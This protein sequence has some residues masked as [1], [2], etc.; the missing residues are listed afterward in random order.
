MLTTYSDDFEI[1]GL[2]NNNLRFVT[3]S[4]LHV[5]FLIYLIISL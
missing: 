1:L 2:R 3:F 4:L 5:L